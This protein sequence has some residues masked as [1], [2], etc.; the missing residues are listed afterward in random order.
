MTSTE[1]QDEGTAAGSAS[2]YSTGGGGFSFER[3]VAVRYLAAMLSGR[4]RPELGDRRV[5]QVSFQQ[6]SVAPADDLHVLGR[7]DGEEEPSLEMWIAVR[8]RVR[9]T[10][11]DERTQQLM[12]TLLGAAGLPQAKN[13][14]RLVVVCVAGHPNPVA[15]AEVGELADLAR[16]RSEESFRQELRRARRQLKSRYKHLDDLVEAARPQGGEASVWKLLRQLRVLMVRLEPSNEEDW[17]ALLGEMEGWSRDQDLAGAVAL[18][19][20]LEAL[21]GQ[22]GPEAAQVDRAKLCRDC[23]PVLD[24]RKRLL[25]AAWSELRRL[26]SEA[27]GAVRDR[28]G[29]SHP[30]VLPRD[31]ARQDLETVLMSERVLM[32]SGVSGTGKSALV[33]SALDHLAEVR[34]DECES[35]YL[36]LR[37]LPRQAVAMRA[38]L[39]APLGEVLA[40]MSAPKRLVVIDAADIAAET[41]ETSLAAIVTDAVA[42]DASVCVVAAT[43]A[44]ETV[45]GIVAAAA[46]VTPRI[47]TVPALT[48]GEIDALA[49]VFPALGRMASNARARELL[50]RPVIADHLARAGIGDT[51]LSEGAA[52]EVIWSKLV[53]GEP[54]QGQGSPDS[55]DQAMRRLAHNQLAPHDPDVVYAQLDGEALAGLRQDGILR[56]A[57]RSGA[58]LPDFAHDMLRDFAGSESPH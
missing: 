56:A 6:S 15:A 7:R 39:A 51:P 18:R 22:Y 36:N 24:S 11:G 14:Q 30:V 48:D 29:H 12:Q 47:H 37:H 55:R 58:A 32:V 38:L 4:P 27:R 26:E 19:S 16:E 45:R 21:A 49:E 53:R 35:A 42:A 41:D 13:R 50:R 28:C 3:R 44:G 52:M 8:R 57:S 46:G 31:D 25:Q 2:P 20:H 54:R 1:S 5:V 10:L 40:E 43:E 17:A 9:F 34:G 23:H 33:C